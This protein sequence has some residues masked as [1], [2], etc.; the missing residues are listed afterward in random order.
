MRARAPP[1]RRSPH[2][3]FTA[4]AIGAGLVR[5]IVLSFYDIVIDLGLA[6]RLKAMIVDVER[7]IAAYLDSSDQR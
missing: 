2:G 1:P 6:V 7:S 4:F 3:S 5:W